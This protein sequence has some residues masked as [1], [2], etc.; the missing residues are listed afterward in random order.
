[1]SIPFVL[2]LRL[3]WS[4][5]KAITIPA[6]NSNSNCKTPIRS[7]FGIEQILINAKKF[8]ETEIVIH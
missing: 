3:H 1:M 6:V 5:F 2:K 8:P 7:G 4:Y